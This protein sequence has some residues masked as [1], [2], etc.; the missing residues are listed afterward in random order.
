MKKI[1]IF[2]LCI[3]LFFGIS[4]LIF[5]DI[6][7][8]ESLKKEIRCYPHAQI[9]HTLDVTDMAMAKLNVTDRFSKILNFYDTELN[10][11]G[12]K[13]NTITK[14]ENKFTILADK[15]KNNIVIDANLNNSGDSTI[16]ITMDSK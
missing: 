12:W 3:V 8:P 11:M 14:K 1:K 4:G 9:S 13:I 6:E 16:T 15:G 5:A 7:Y 10:K 2:S